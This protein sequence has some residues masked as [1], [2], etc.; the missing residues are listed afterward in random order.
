VTVSVRRVMV[1]MSESYAFADLYA[2]VWANLRALV[3]P[4][5]SGAS[6]G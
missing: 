6:S 3:M 5:P 1:S 4:R 2:R